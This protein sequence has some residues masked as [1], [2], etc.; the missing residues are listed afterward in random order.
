MEVKKKYSHVIWDWNGTL[1]DDVDWCIE[2]INIML[3]K[4]GIQTIQSVAEY[5]KAFCFPIIQ[6]YINV[7]FDF[8]KEPFED[9]AR[10]YISLYHSGKSGNCKLHA[11]TEAVLANIKERGIEQIILSA[12]ETNNLLSQISEFDIADFFD[13]MLGISDIY[14]KSKIEI[15]LDYISRKNVSNAILIGD[16]RHDYEVAKAL[17]VDCVLI[18]NGHQSKDELLSCNVPIID[19]ISLVVE[20]IK[21]V[22]IL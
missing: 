12:S 22:T 15:G 18:P 17:G 1:F 7:G 10:E 5:H 6:Y 4:R 13:E 20:Y 2:V 16:T 19:D 14:A 11:G 9:L 3:A 8:D 21:R